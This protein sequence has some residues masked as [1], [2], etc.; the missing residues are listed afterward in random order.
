VPDGVPQA[1]IVDSG[2]HAAPKHEFHD[3]KYHRVAYAPVAVTRFREYFPA[4]TN[5]FDATTLAGSAFLADVPSSVRPEAPAVLYALPLFA[6]DTPP[7]TPGVATR[8]RRGGGLRIYLDRPWFSSGDGELLGLVFQDGT[9]FLNLPE[10]LKPLVTQWG[11]DPIWAAGPAPDRAFAAHFKDAVTTGG[12]LDLAETGVGTVS[13]AGYPVVFDPHRRLWRADVE[14][15]T[16]DAYW[17]FI[18]LALARFQP[19]SVP[20]VELSRV[21][22]SDFVQLPPTRV[23]AITVG[24][25]T[26]HV[27]V[28]GP[29]YVDSELIRTVGTTLPSLGGAPASNGLS[30]IEVV[31]ETCP[32]AVDP[33]NDLAW[34]PVGATRVLLVQDPTMPGRWEGDVTFA[35]P[36]TPGR[37]RLTVQ[38]FEWL[39]TDDD[40][41]SGPQPGVRAAAVQHDV[42]VARRLVFADVFAL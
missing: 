8:T 14:I 2:S 42:K 3:T 11:A 16:G 21:V 9:P 13:V 31:I 19:K 38:E 17:P 40:V 29:V 15:E 1:G 7:G 32:P 25:P 36:I 33:A 4:A 30:E 5:T 41:W 12:G 24:V 28:K 18:R 27:V 10:A 23:T 37:T 6:W 35:G 20:G 22:R 39:R 34:T 26:I